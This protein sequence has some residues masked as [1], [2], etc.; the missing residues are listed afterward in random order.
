[1]ASK[2]GGTAEICPVCSE[3]VYPLDRFVI[4]KMVIHKAC[5]KCKHCGGKLG[6]SNFAAVNQQVYC[7]THYLQLFRESGGRYDK[8]FGDGGFEKKST[9][10]SYVPGQ[11]KGVGA[12]TTPPSAS[13]SPAKPSP[14]AAAA[15]AEPVEAAPPSVKEML[16]KFNEPASPAAAAASPSAKSPAAEASPSPSS[17]G[18]RVK[19]MM[20]RFQKGG[21]EEQSELN[22]S[23][24]SLNSSRVS[25]SGAA[26]SLSERIK[27]YSANASST[28]AATAAGKEQAAVGSSA[29]GPAQ[30]VGKLADRLQQY[31][32]TAKEGDAKHQ[33]EESA[34]VV[35]AAEEEE[36]APKEEAT[37]VEEELT[38]VVKE[39]QAPVVEEEQA[40]VVVEEEQT[41]VVEEEQTPVVE[42]EQTPVVEEEEQASVVVE[43]APVEEG[44]T[45]APAAEEPESEIVQQQQ[46]PVAAEEEQAFAA[47]AEQIP[48][49]EEEQTP[50]ADEEIPIGEEQSPMEDEEHAPVK[51]E[52][53]TPIGEAPITEEEPAPIEEEANEQLHSTPIKE[54]NSTG[55]EPRSIMKRDDS[56]RTPGDD[57]SVRFGGAVEVMEEFTTPDGKSKNDDDD[58]DNE[59]EEEEDDTAT[60]TPIE[61]VRSSS[62]HSA[63][64]GSALAL[65]LNIMD[66]QTRQVRQQRQEERSPTPPPP[67]LSPGS[68]HAPHLEN[69]SSLLSPLAAAAA[70]AEVSSPPSGTMNLGALLP[71]Y[72]VDTTQGKLQ[73]HQYFSGGWGMLFSHPADFTPVCTTELRIAGDL[74]DEFAS[75]QC[76]LLALSCD[77]V[78]SH[79][80]WIKDLGPGEFPFPII[81][82]ESREMATRLGMLD[83]VAKDQAGI[84]LTARAVFVF[85]PDLRLKLSVLYPATTGRNFYE[86]VR[87]L[88]SLQLANH[89]KLA[90]PVDWKQGDDCLVLAGSSDEFSDVRS[91]ALPS[92]KEY[93]Q[94]TSDPSA[95]L[96][97]EQ[98]A[99]RHVSFC[100]PNHDAGASYGNTGLN[101]GDELLDFTAESTLGP[102]TFSDLFAQASKWVAVFSHPVDFAPVCTTELLRL[103]ELEHEFTNRNCNVVAI[104][105]DS[106]ESHQVWVA[107]VEALGNCKVG[108]PLVADESREI[109]AG[110]GMGPAASKDDEGSL[111]PSS[112]TA[113]AVLLCSPDRKLKLSMLYPASTGHS[114]LEVL[115]ALDSLQLTFQHRLAT[116]G[117]WKQG[118][119]C[120]VASSV[121]EEEAHE[122]FPSGVRVEDLPSGKAYLRYTDQPSS[123]E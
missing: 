94:Y 7:K 38:P 71:D 5:F 69:E 55:E 97:A 1:M 6:L 9:D 99:E 95:L 2:F 23:S 4:E 74:F 25:A 122:L 61:R 57:R 93:I 109:M 20:K 77:S 10:Q 68:H 78:E 48:A 120:I 86:L 89:V 90:T 17:G 91:V 76:K 98:L 39:E 100:A 105:C 11:F 30:G 121:T 116:P 59:E 62:G 110:L 43:Q 36:Q 50:A 119:K 112:N 41:P 8:A 52:E 45:E 14:V 103:A 46:V 15:V 73:L 72:E 58:D 82:D 84:P 49:A 66:Q 123:Q 47:E 75:R 24:E 81:A 21:G 56:F 18:S 114:M 87:A 34:E 104:A 29:A 113:R 26:S 67:L 19:D 115:R 60:Y 16:K 108:F 27:L 79:L 22:T 28:T 63:T 37:A 106:V 42:E 64:K 32:A 85:G 31:V 101:L 13:A 117:N 35:V 40:P 111:L 51:E 92:G 118:N 107:D 88:D 83:A 44:Q 80:E 12:P 102:L 96:D 33:K 54:R 53:Q 3:K 65:Y 70:A